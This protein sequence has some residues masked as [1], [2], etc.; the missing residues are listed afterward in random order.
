MGFCSVGS[1]DVCRSN[2]LPSIGGRNARSLFG[3]GRRVPA[4][5]LIATI[6]SPHKPE[7][8]TTFHALLLQHRTDNQSQL[9]PV[10]QIV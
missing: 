2:G 3:G 10:A 1:R 5:Y 8:L 7:Q 4:A 9:Q 6:T